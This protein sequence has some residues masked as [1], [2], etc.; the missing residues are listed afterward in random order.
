LVSEYKESDLFELKAL[1]DDT[2]EDCYYDF[3]GI[4]VVSFF[5]DYHNIDR[6]KE[7]AESGKT[8]IYRENGTMIATGTLIDNYISSVYVLKNHQNK[9]L[10]K[11]IVDILI[12]KARTDSIKKLVLDSTP[13]AKK[14]YERI[15]FTVVEETI[16][17]V[18]EI[19]P[20]PY[21]VMEKVL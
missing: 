8:F 11:Q 10:G 6:I 3:Y 9:R 2:I 1:I 7:R 12:E 18:D 4:K 13:G 15:G 16:Q 19:F 14:F 17:W 5:I 20:L 21:F